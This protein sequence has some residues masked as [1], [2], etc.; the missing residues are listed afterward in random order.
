[1]FQVCQLNFLKDSSC[2]PRDEVY[3]KY[4]TSGRIYVRQ[5]D[6]FLNPCEVYRLLNGLCLEM[7]WAYAD[8]HG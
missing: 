2:K 8:M 1:M 7:V 5:G 4:L 6:L 3:G